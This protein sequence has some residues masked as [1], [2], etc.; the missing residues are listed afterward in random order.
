MLFGTS[1]SLTKQMMTKPKMPEINLPPPPPPP[2]TIDEAARREEFSRK[3]ARRKG[4][5]RNIYTKPSETARPSVAMKTLL[6]G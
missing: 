6:G 1:A 4:R 5:M 3:A 2:P